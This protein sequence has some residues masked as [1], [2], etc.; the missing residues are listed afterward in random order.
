MRKKRYSYYQIGW[1]RWVNAKILKLLNVLYPV[2]IKASVAVD[3]TCGY[4]F[5][6][7]WNN[8]TMTPC[9]SKAAF[10]NILWKNTRKPAY[11]NS[12]IGWWSGNAIYL[13]GVIAHLNVVTKSGWKAPA[14]IYPEIINIGEHVRTHVLKSA[15]VVSTFQFLPEMVNSTLLRWTRIQ[16]EHPVTKKWCYRQ[17]KNSYALHGLPL[18]V[19]QIK[20][21]FCRNW[22]SYQQK[23]KSIMQAQV[24]SLMHSQVDLVY[25]RD[26]MLRWLCC[27]SLWFNVGKLIGETREIAISRI[28]KDALWTYRDGKTNEL[29]IHYEWWNFQKGGTNIHCSRKTLGLAEK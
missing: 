20:L 28:W 15:I 19:T 27:S 26:R 21:T 25:V 24:Q 16:V 22:M 3:A 13:A 10:S 11:W 2:I 9:G 12:E 23:I 4:S 29:P 5:W 7:I 8:H 17:S 6:K 14:P 1:G 18:S